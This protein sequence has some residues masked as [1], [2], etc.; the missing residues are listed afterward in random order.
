MRDLNSQIPDECYW[1][2]KA[3]MTSL[4]HSLLFIL[5]TLVVRA[6]D[7][8]TRARQRRP[9]GTPEPPYAVS[10]KQS[11]GPQNLNR[12]AGCFAGAG[13]P[14]SPD[15]DSLSTGTTLTT[16]GEELPASSPSGGGRE[17]VTRSSGCAKPETKDKR[18]SSQGMDLRSRFQSKQS[19]E[20]SKEGTTCSGLF[21]L[22]TMTSP[23]RLL[24]HL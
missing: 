21:T 12:D 9:G 2:P 18:T 11:P 10:T 20:S 13:T 14:D 3:R 1:Q 24:P 19:A 15:D 17:D 5:L 6:E 23:C 22:G 8:G 4:A 16:P 7:L